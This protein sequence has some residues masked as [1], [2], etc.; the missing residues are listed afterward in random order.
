MDDQYLP[1]TSS[2][3][4]QDTGYGLLACMAVG[5]KVTVV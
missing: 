4:M 3:G 5:L 1:S 2:R